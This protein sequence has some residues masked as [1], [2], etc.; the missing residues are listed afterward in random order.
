MA[1][2]RGHKLAGVHPDLVAAVKKAA[3]TFNI[4]VLEGVRSK[5]R[6]KE[7]VETGMSQTEDSKHFIQEDGYGHAVDIAP[8]PINWEDRD[9]FLA[10]NFYVAGVAKGMGVEVRQGVDWDEDLNIKEHSLFDGP[11][12]ELETK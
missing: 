11:H 8:D 2:R 12:I 6:Q 4:V 10:L 5:E 9:A 3:E 7:L 1:L